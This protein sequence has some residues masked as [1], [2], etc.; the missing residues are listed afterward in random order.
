MKELRAGMFCLSMPC[1]RLPSRPLA[2]P[3][4]PHLPRPRLP[5]LL[6]LPRQLDLLPHRRRDQHLPPR[7]PLRPAQRQPPR[8]RRHAGE[9]VPRLHLLR[10]L[11]LLQRQPARLRRLLRAAGHQ[12]YH[13][14]QRSPGQARRKDPGQR[15]PLHPRPRRDQGHLHHPAR[16][17]LHHLRAAAPATASTSPSTTSAAARSP[18]SKTS[19]QPS[20]TRSAPASPPSSPPS[21][22]T[23]NRSPRKTLHPFFLSNSAHTATPSCVTISSATQEACHGQQT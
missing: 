8:R 21:A 23:P 5:S 3:S 9:P 19:P 22:S 6:R 14:P 11:R 18:A 16:R 1:C 4:H 17:D 20:L 13:R 7:R 10:R 12:H 15:Y 2:N